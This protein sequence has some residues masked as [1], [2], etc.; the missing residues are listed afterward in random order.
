[1]EKKKISQGYLIYISFFFIVINIIGCGVYY[2]TGSYGF[3]YD[4]Y[5]S[6][7]YEKWI[8]KSTK[9]LEK[10]HGER[11][12]RGKGY[13]YMMSLFSG[14]DVVYQIDCQV[15]GEILQGRYNEEKSMSA[16]EQ[17]G[18]INAKASG[19]GKTALM[20]ASENRSI[21][22][23]KFLIG[24]GADLELKNAEG[25]TA[26][27]LAAEA[28]A[29]NSVKLLVKAGVDINAKDSIGRTAL[30]LAIKELRWG[31][32]YKDARVAKFLI[33]TGADVNIRDDAGMTVLMLAI[34][35]DYLEIVESLI[36]KGA[37]VN[38]KDGKGRTPLMCAFYA[39]RLSDKQRVS[40]VKLLIEH[41]ADVN[42]KDD[43]GEPLL[44]HSPS[45]EITKLILKED[46]DP[47]VGANAL[48]WAT[49]EELF[50]LKAKGI[51]VDVKEGDSKK[52]L[53]GAAY[54]NYHEIAKLL[55]QKGVNVNFQGNEVGF[56]PLIEAAARESFET[57]KILIDAGADVNAKDKYGRTVLMEGSGDRRIIALL[58][59][60]GVNINAV[61]YKGETAL[62]QVVNRGDYEAVELLVQAGADIDIRD[63][64]GKTALMYAAQRRPR[65]RDVKIA[66]Y[67]IESGADINIRD[68]K[69]ETALM[70]ALNVQKRY[71]RGNK[72]R[73]MINIIKILKQR[74]AK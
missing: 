31:C 48:S 18:D 53:M 47:T 21:E 39:P 56:T 15:I 54:S 29:L 45:L 8:E 13:G 67:L 58:I 35:L 12:G 26:L 59:K 37:D 14:K 40:L 24:K 51:D 30:M 19:T 4:V 66:S 55:I 74:R 23:M 50:Q 2:Q 6:Y 64:E 65:E 33:R 46:I 11:C 3:H 68:N 60:S 10:Y 16:V 57:A 61:N 32:G 42:Y 9:S 49:Q 20:F 1:M 62:M 7:A 17:T 22:R 71:P 41:G 5:G 69:R 43:N 44:K 25:K 72:D 38:V 73:D 28:N 63:K 70:K 34:N 27:M 36:N 52:A